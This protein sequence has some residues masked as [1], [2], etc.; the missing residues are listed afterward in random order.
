MKLVLR[1]SSCCVDSNLCCTKYF[2]FHISLH[3]LSSNCMRKPTKTTRLYAISGTKRF[4]A[5]EGKQE[6][7][8]SSLLLPLKC[9]CIFVEKGLTGVCWWVGKTYGHHEQMHMCGKSQEISKADK[10]IAWAYMAG[11]K[12]ENSHSNLL[13]IWFPSSS[14]GCSRNPTVAHLRRNYVEVERKP[15]DLYWCLARVSFQ[16]TRPFLQPLF[17]QAHSTHSPVRW[18]APGSTGNMVYG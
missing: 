6:I 1:E 8:F 12:V 18:E 3:I 16:E 15:C 14:G 7:I 2:N 13:P 5:T 10:Y 17:D 11:K 4:R 9:F